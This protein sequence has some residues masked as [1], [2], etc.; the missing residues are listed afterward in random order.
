M[1]PS[2][3]DHQLTQSRPT[4]RALL[5]PRAFGQC[6]G[7][8][9]LLTVLHIFAS[10]RMIRF[11]SSGASKRCATRVQHRGWRL[12]EINRLGNQQVPEGRVP[13]LRAVQALYGW[14]CSSAGLYSCCFGSLV[15][16]QFR[17]QTPWRLRV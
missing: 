2:L 15:A 17:I 5:V 11:T 9:R 12:W 8:Y 16:E 3:A 4:L 1:A 14:S 7:L 6:W 10:R 13:P